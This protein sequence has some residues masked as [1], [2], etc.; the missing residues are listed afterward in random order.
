MRLRPQGLAHLMGWL[1]ICCAPRYLGMY[2]CCLVES[3]IVGEHLEA[4]GVV[5][6]IGPS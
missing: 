1:A 4:G 3:L 6:H 5:V 2:G